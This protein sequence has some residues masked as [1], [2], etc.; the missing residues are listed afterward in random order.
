MSLSEPFP[1]TRRDV[2][3]RVGQ[4]GRVRHK[5][6]L[7]ARLADRYSVAWIRREISVVAGRGDVAQ[8]F[9]ANHRIIQA[10]IDDLGAEAERVGDNANTQR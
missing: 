8:N 1:D 9:L 10:C 4:A 2:I 3:E 6:V 7:A 5:V